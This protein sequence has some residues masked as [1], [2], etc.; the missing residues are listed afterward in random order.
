MK[1]N[2]RKKGRVG[3]LERR[4]MFRANAVRE[5]VKKGKISYDDSWG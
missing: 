1:D 2:L 3:G 4:E 5:R